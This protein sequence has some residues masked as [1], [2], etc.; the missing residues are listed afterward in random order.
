[1]AKNIKILS[2]FFIANI[3]L[4]VLVVPF[5]KNSVSFHARTQTYPPAGTV[6]IPVT[7]NPG[8]TTNSLQLQSFPF[9]TATPTPS[10][11]PVP[12]P[13][14]A[15][16]AGGAIGGCGTGA[17]DPAPPDTYTRVIYQGKTLN[18][19][20]KTMLQ[21]ADKYAKGMGIPV[22][23][24]LLQ[25]SY[26]KGGVGASAGTHDGG[27]AIDISVNNLNTAQRTSAVQALRMAGFAAWL[28]TPSQGPWPYHIH[29]I[30]IGDKQMS[31]GAA[32]Q[33]RDYLAGRNGLAN[34]APDKTPRP[35]PSW[36][37][38]GTC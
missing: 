32:S 5:L 13:T 23:F 8:P 25:G 17:I 34:H 9:V 22:P 18:V 35:M 14:T 10:P 31:S 7:D 27:G 26:N 33:V 28:R 2:F 11:T 29:A 19:R 16:I 12:S 38:K 30:A 21:T 20:T 15:P 6:V 37:G 24:D 1:M 3:F 36:A 4:L